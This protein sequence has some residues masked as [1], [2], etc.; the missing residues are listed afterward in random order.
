MLRSLS[1]A[2]VALGLA[3]C[4]GSKSETDA[5]GSSV[6]SAPAET[7]SPFKVSDAYVRTP[8]EGQTSTAAYFNISS[9]SDRNALIVGVTASK[10]RVAE[11]HSH[12][13]TGGMMAMAKVEQV[14]LE[15]GSSV[16]FRQ[17]G[18]HIMLFDVAEDVEEGD[19]VEITLDIFSNSKTT[20]VTFDAPVRPLG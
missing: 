18:Y 13:M 9:E 17:L 16:E 15:A 19:T 7:A 8:M 10:A 5:S 11:M 20:R 12:S 3:A 1:V 6:S 4:G 14:E 2:L